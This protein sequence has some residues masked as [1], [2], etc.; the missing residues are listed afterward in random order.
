VLNEAYV[1]AHRKEEE[2]RTGKDPQ[3]QRAKGYELFKAAGATYT[4]LD[5]AFE[6]WP[7]NLGTN[8]KRLNANEMDV[9]GAMLLQVSLHSKLSRRSRARLQTWKSEDIASP[10]EA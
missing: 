1:K 2:K 10:T 5:S 6:N 8:L 3:A 7:V 4:P 9:I